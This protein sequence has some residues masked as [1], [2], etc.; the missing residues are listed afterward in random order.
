MYLDE[1]NFM[2]KKHLTC[3]YAKK[4]MNQTLDKEGIRAKTMSAV[5]VISS[6]HGLVDYYITIGAFNSDLF[7]DFLGMLH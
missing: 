7:I 6:E 5:V 1:T 2:P 4:Y 3:A